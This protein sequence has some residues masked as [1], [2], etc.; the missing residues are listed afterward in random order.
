[1]SGKEKKTQKSKKSS[2]DELEEK[3]KRGLILLL[4][5][6]DRVEYEENKEEFFRE[7]F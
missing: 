1:M 4:K 3:A 6:I 2:L 5:G 7:V